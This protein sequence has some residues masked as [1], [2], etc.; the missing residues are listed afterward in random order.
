M[1]SLEHRR[2][3][4]TEFCDQMGRELVIQ[5]LRMD[6]IWRKGSNLRDQSADAALLQGEGEDSFGVGPDRSA[7]PRAGELDRKQVVS[8]SLMADGSVA[9]CKEAHSVPSV[10]KQF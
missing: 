9:A 7:S 8:W 5:V 1:K 4:A 2:A 3:E 10:P 6:D